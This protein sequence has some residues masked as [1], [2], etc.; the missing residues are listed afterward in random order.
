[1]TTEA[2]D[3]GPRD[4]AAGALLTLAWYAMPDVVR[5]RPLRTALKVALLAGGAAWVVP[6]VKLYR[7]EIVELLVDRDWSGREIAIGTG[8]LAAGTGLTVAA[9]KAIFGYGE[10][11]RGRDV[12]LAHTAPALVMALMAGASALLPMPAPQQTPK[13]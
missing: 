11:R 4:A 10:R 8:A 5:S 6:F 2:H 12:Q 1:M 13:H 9:E 7:D 3:P